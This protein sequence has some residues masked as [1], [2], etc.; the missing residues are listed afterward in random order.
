MAI[1]DK[2]LGVIK[3]VA[4]SV[5]ISLTTGQKLM[6]KGTGICLC[7]GSLLCEQGQVIAEE[8]SEFELA[9][10]EAKAPSCLAYS[11]KITHSPAFPKDL[12]WHNWLMPYTE[13]K[14]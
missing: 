8:A 2:E 12:P 1:I 6:K 3:V 14:G 9:E 5:D 4:F 10:V 13:R 7:L 11:K